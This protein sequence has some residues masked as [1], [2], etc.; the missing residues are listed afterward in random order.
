MAA[1]FATNTLNMGKG[2]A[3]NFAKVISATSG[4]LVGGG[5]ENA[6]AVNIAGTTGANA[7]ENNFL[8]HTQAAQMKKEFEACN[9]KAG[10]C[11]DTEVKAISQK[12]L[13]LSNKNIDAVN[14][15]IAKG[16]AACVT[17]LESQAATAREVDSAI[18]FGYSSVATVFVGLQNNVNEYG[19]TKGTASLFG[20]DV[21]QAQEVAQFRQDSCAGLSASA[22]DGLVKQALDDR[23]TRAAIL[24]AVGGLMPRAVNGLR[25]LAVPKGGAAVSV[26]PSAGGKPDTMLPEAELA[27]NKPSGKSALEVPSSNKVSGGVVEP[28]VT[29][30]GTVNGTV[31]E[32]V[33]QTAKIG[34][35]NDP[36]LIADRVAAKTEAKGK[37]FP[38]GTVA[39]SHAEIGVI[40]Q[41]F[42]AG[43][44]KGADMS[45]AVSG[46]D[47]C[48][49]C[50]G[51]IAAAADAA[52]LRS[53]TIHAVDEKTLLPKTYYWQP[54]MKSIKQNP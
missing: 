37:P 17:K 53:L 51:D 23:M 54:G 52:G 50:K 24:T 19:A 47:V 36:T 8:N 7:A 38:N 10:G 25:T 6:A 32:D 21:Q 34:A 2:D 14:N 48:G 15:C 35:T 12:Y 4:V 28:V 42:N 26:K 40:Q 41:A 16:D 33:N 5:G 3:L 1:D 20:T 11:L 9:S 18:P 43:K 30:K 27:S 22:C 31:F 13:A 29:A 39:D 44:T 46:K 45:M 49:Y